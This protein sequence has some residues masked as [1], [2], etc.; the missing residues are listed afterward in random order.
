MK[1]LLISILLLAILQPVSAELVNLNPNPDGEPWYVGG[2]RPLTHSDSLYLQSLPKLRLTTEQARR[3][4]PAEI[5]N[6]QHPYFRPIFSQDG[7]S[8]GQ[9]SGIGYN[10][11]YEIDWERGVSADTPENQYP[12]HY[13]WNFLNRG[14]GGGSWYWDGWNIIDAGGCPN[15][16]TYGGDI[17]TGGRTRWMDGYNLYRAGMDNRVLEM[18]SI[19]VGDSLGLAT[20]KAWMNDH[21]DDSEIG[22]L[23][24]FACGVSGMDIVY[25]NDDNPDPGKQ[26]VTRWDPDMNHAMTFVGYNDSIRYDYNNDGQY[27]NDIDI[28]GDEIVDMRDWEMGALIVANSWG[29]D[30]GDGGKIYM[31]Y[32]L[33]AEDGSDGGIWLNTVHVLRA[34]ETYSPL[35]TAKATITHYCRNKLKISAGI[36]A[37]PDADEPE[38]S[39]DFPM[40]NFQGGEH[41]MSGGQSGADIT[42]EIGLDVTPLLS[43]V[44]LGETF[45]FFLI[46][47]ENDPENSS[48]GSINH[49]ALIDET[50]DEPVEYEWSQDAVL[51]NNN[52]VTYCPV[53]AAIDFDRV[54]IPEQNIPA[55]TVDE[56][57]EYPFIAQNGEPPYTWNLLMDYNETSAVSEFPD[58]GGSQIYPSDNDD[59]FSRQELQFYFPFYGELHDHIFIGTDGSIGFEYNTTSARNASAVINNRIITPYGTDLMLVPE[60]GDGIWIAS[61]SLQMKIKWISSRFEEPDFD[62]EMIACLHKSG[63]IDFFYGD[64]DPSSNWVAGISAGDGVN[65]EILTISGE[66]QIEAE[67]HHTFGY[68]NL[69]D[70]MEL[71]ED[72]ILQGAPTED[73]QSWQLS[74][75]VEDFNRVSA[76]RTFTFTTG[77]SGSGQNPAP[78]ALELSQNVP[79]PFNPTTTISYS[80]PQK[81]KVEIEV[82]NIKGQKVTTLVNES[83][84]AG[85]H[86]AIWDGRDSSD[87]PCSSGIY[88]YRLQNGS[89]TQTRKMLLLQ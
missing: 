28:N 16:E 27:T 35:M 40:F 14:N 3:N 88:F 48:F 58:F 34:R 33:L 61:D 10:F 62:L 7:G 9:A 23:A 30:W 45:Q 50:Q 83:K 44:E 25:L 26:C 75:L 69:P 79:N 2:L 42:I 73:D 64:V 71:T 11:T 29:T 63:E 4:R 15:I 56:P 67:Y 59:G 24:N 60:D 77:E 57:Y 47:E 76:Q 84:E 54:E 55:A 49:L 17:A 21:L 19:Y 8:C 66:N 85:S 53:N 22:G 39:I 72:G 80:I 31:M 51:I 82:F 13:T 6:T 36:A 86:S 32:K 5:D 43:F 52:D 37:D 46:V 87:K 68:P 18:S 70:N 41:Y 81:G 38:Q 89:H 65:Y 74:V 1:T 12:T 78:F 20:L